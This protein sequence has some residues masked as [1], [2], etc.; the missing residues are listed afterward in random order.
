MYILS[1]FIIETIC[2]CETHM[3]PIMTNSIDGQDHEDKYFDTSKKILS[4]EMTMCK[5]EA[6]VSYL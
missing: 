4:Q 2:F 3:L 6:L 1:I 5:M